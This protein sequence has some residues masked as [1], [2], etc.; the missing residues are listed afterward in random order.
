MSGPI[1]G[2]ARTRG[3]EV[4]VHPGGALADLRVE[5]SA[6]RQ[7][8]HALATT[9]LDLVARATAEADARAANTLG[10]QVAAAAGLGADAALAESVEA[11]TPDSWRAR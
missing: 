9:L 11:T 6:L 7:G 2:A 1:T 5:E 3:V 10:P 4:R 8:G